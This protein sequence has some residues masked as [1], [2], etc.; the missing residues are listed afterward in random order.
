MVR[1]WFLSNWYLLHSHC[2]CSWTRMK[3]S[4]V[5][6]LRCGSCSST[7]LWGVA[8]LMLLVRSGCEEV[9]ARSTSEMKVFCLL[10]LHGKAARLSLLC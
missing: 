5:M 6:M 1:R 10:P 2:D 3:L 4:L 7:L 8:S 9:M